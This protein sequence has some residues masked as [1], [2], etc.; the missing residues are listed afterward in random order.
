MSV[1]VI[2]LKVTGKKNAKSGCLFMGNVTL[3]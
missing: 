3:V 2:S 1:F